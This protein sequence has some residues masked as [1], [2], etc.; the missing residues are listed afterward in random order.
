M[1]YVPCG[2]IDA[3]QADEYWKKFPNIVEK[4]IEY[5]PEIAL[6][7]ASQE[8]PGANLVVWQK[9]QTVAI[10]YYTI[11]REL[12]GTGTYE[13]LATIP[14]DMQSIYVDEHANNSKQAHKYKISATNFCGDESPVSPPHKTI[15]LEKKGSVSSRM[16]LVWDNYEGF[17]FDQYS[18]YR[19]TSTGIEEISKE[20]AVGDPL[21]IYEKGEC[22]DTI[23]PLKTTITY[24]DVKPVTNTRAYYVAVKLPKEINV[25][26]P[27]LKAEG[28]P[29]TICISNI[30][31]VENETA[32]NDIVEYRARVYAKEGAIVVENAENKPVAIYNAVGH[33]IAR[34]IGDCTV[35]VQQNGAYIVDKWWFYRYGRVVSKVVECVGKVGGKWDLNAYLLK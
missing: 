30:A 24:T 14:Y 31:E 23:F 9:E 34:E 15:H 12:A 35:D 8:I 6:V 19:V 3:Y 4:K 5:S 25:N 27:L 17:S 10:D 29:F 26:D 1:I 28:G 7:T 32:V 21:Y 16:D 11:Y 18:V 13:E 20:V 33:S 2:L 22:V